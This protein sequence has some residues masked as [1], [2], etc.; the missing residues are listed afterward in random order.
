MGGKGPRDTLICRD[1]DSGDEA[2]ADEASLNL[3]PGIRM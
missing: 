3:R 2:A 1:I